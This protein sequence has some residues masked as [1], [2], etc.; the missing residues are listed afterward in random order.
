MTG[1][2]KLCE[3]CLDPSYSRWIETLEG[4]TRCA[5]CYGKTPPVSFPIIFTS[6]SRVLHPLTFSH[7]IRVRYNMWAT[8]SDIYVHI[9]FNPFESESSSTTC[10][11]EILPTPF[12]CFYCSVLVQYVSWQDETHPRVMTKSRGKVS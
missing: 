4:S 6:K 9:G 2:E 3:S 10:R 7:L 5:T 8:S 12:V 1:E 11:H